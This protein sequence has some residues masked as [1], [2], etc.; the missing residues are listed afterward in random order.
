MVF[1][2]GFLFSRVELDTLINLLL[3]IDPE[4]WDERFRDLN[5]G[6]NGSLDR[7]EIRD[8]F[9]SA[10][11]ELSNQ[12]LD[13]I[14]QRLD[15]DSDGTVSLE[16]FKSMAYE[17]HRAAGARRYRFSWKSLAAKVVKGRKKTGTNRKLDAAF[18]LADV[19]KIENLAFSPGSENSFTA[20]SECKQ[21]TLAVYIK[22]ES[23]PIMVT[24]G[25]PGHAV[26]WMETFS[27]CMASFKSHFPAEFS[28]ECE[29]SRR[30]L[31]IGS[32]DAP[33]TRKKKNRVSRAAFLNSG[34]SWGDDDDTDEDYEDGS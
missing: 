23:E 8:F 20:Y 21:S 3:D 28:D 30:G 11:I 25:K 15:S 4:R 5:T 6:H 1:T 10:G 19:E 33:K 34:I 12:T 32:D 22:G 18:Q 2:Y 14:V 24:C 17:A 31:L 29:N 26:A 9:H 27:T 7:R 13:D 16:D